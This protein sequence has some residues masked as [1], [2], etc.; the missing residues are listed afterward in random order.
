MTKADI[1][2]LIT[3]LTYSEADV[4]TDACD[5]FIDD[6]L[7]D[8]AKSPKAPLTAS[9]TFNTAIGISEYSYDSLDIDAVKLIGM[10]YVN[11][12]LWPTTVRDLEQLSKTYRADTGT[13]YA[14]TTDEETAHAFEVYP[15]PTAMGVVRGVYT[16]KRS[17]NIQEWLGLYIAFKVMYLEFSRPSNHQDMDYAKLCGEI[18]E[19]LRIVMGV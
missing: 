13:P 14:Y 1:L 2:T 7:D 12:T 16:S 4:S 9:D 5:R 10:S 18:A 11:A 17:T 19:L 8:L 3:S 15:I 6:V